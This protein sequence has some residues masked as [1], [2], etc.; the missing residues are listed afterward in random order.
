MFWLSLSLK[1]GIPIRE[2]QEK[3]DSRDFL[4]YQ[5]YDQMEPIGGSRFDMGIGIVCHVLS[6]LN[7]VKDTKIS[8]FMPDY[9]VQVKPKKTPEQM[10]STLSMFTNA[11]GGEVK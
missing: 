8:D 1:M 5:L 7:G 9:G 10:W 4:L 6:K 2:L 3:V 11:A